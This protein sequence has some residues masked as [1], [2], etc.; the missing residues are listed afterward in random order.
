[1]FKN[2][3]EVVNALE[4]GI[5]VLATRPGR[6]QER[7]IEA[8]HK[9]LHMIRPEDIAG[10]DLNADAQPYWREVVQAVTAR[11][12]DKRGSY[13]PSIQAMTEDEAC[14]IASRVTA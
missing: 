12:D 3:R 8:F 6:V 2:L 9:E 10:P 11:H 4:V 13:E 5:D 7:L 14:R 1:M